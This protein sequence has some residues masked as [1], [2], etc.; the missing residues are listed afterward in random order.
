MKIPKTELA[1]LLG[2]AP[3]PVTQ[4]PV[5]STSECQADPWSSRMCQ[6][7]TKSCT[8]DHG[9]PLHETPGH[10]SERYTPLHRDLAAALPRLWLKAQA[11]GSRSEH[12]K[13][14]RELLAWLLQ[15][16]G[17]SVG[18]NSAMRYS[19]GAEL[20]DGKIDL[21]AMEASDTPVLAVEA[22][23]MHQEA[24]LFKLKAAHEKGFPV[25]WVA[26]TAAKT[27]ED[28]R[29]CR[30][31]AMRVLGRGCGEWLL[32]YHLEYGWV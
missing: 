17:Y 4:A 10:Q 12:R 25:L 19:T 22:D 28:A 26:G 5:P 13:K 14:L 24:S 29:E 11:Q 23:W 7:G 32:I 9:Q 18:E 2:A 30:H 16:K 27:R 1:S 20:V 21:L 31:F 15:K 8:V 3:S 6:A